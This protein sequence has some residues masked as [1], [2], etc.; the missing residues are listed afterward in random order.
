MRCQNMFEKIIEKLYLKQ[1]E[2]LVYYDKFMETKT[3]LY[4]NMVGMDLYRNK[5]CKIFFIDINKVGT[6]NGTEGYQKGNEYIHDIIRKIM[7]KPE[8]LDICRVR[9]DKFVIFTTLDFNND[10]ITTIKEISYG[11]MNKDAT[12]EDIESIIEKSENYMK[13]RKYKKSR[14]TKKN[15]QKR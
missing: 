11:Y 10:Y 14:Q 5:E 12:N 2:N 6:I 15:S 4:L 8:I 9:G 1:P 7:Y 3:E 13:I